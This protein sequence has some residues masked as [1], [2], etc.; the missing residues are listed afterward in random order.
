MNKQVIL[1]KQVTSNQGK[2]KQLI[3]SNT[4]LNFK[5]SPSPILYNFFKLLILFH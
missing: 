2:N 1:I 4:Y 3:A 5:K